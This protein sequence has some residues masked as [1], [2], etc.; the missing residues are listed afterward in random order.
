MKKV[1]LFGTG[2]YG[3]EA[4]SFL[5][6][7]NILC[8]AD[9]DKSIQG[10]KVKGIEVIDP[11]YIAEYL[12]K[13]IVV[14]AAREEIVSQ[15]K[16]QLLE[17]NIDQ[18]I[19]YYFIRGYISR[20]GGDVKTFLCECSTDAGVYKYMY[21]C[22]NEQKLRFQEKA[23]FFMRNTDIRSVNKAVGELRKLQLR[24]ADVAYELNKM[25]EESGAQ[26]LLGGGTLIGAVRHQGFIPW[27]DD[28]DFLMIREDYNKFIE[29]YSNKDMLYISD[30]DPNYEAQIYDEMAAKMETSANA[31]EFCFN[32]VF[33]TAYKK[34]KYGAPVIL[35]IFPLDYYREDT[36]YRQLAEYERLIETDIK[37]ISTVKGR[38]EYYKE[39]RNKNP[40][41]SKLPTSK[42]AYGAE[43]VYDVK[44]GTTFY[45]SSD[46]YPL[47]KMKF[48][49][50]YFNVPYKT[51]DF[52]YTE[53]GDIY[54]W[55]ADA[56]E[57]THG[58]EMRYIPYTK[59]NNAIY[60][61]SYNDLQEKVVENYGVDNAG[62]HIY[63]IR[64]FMIT[65]ICEYFKI[66]EQLDEENIKYYV[67]A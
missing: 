51:E 3:L 56:G 46:V 2:R 17:Q 63:V 9:N 27:D 50:Y 40:Y 30:A 16:Y 48:E 44:K 32:G 55:P 59:K 67:Y 19:P 61:D 37:N 38:F 15:M 57:N 53:Y 54:K 31:L 49:N 5:G 28:M 25:V 43:L 4:I 47:K 66:V 26:L 35:D 36:E 10:K 41:I 58:R 64:K 23:E 13:A 20:N 34:N 22:E 11:N 62:E 21:E 1:I 8:F 14:L 65:D 6:R 42:I 33:I 29:Y 39:L 52:L 18:F 7:E 45:K 60:I 12:D 24:Y